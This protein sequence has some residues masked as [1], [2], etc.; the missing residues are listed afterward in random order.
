MDW[1]EKVGKG[2]A[3]GLAKGQAKGLAEV[4]A[5]ALFFSS[6]TGRRISLRNPPISRIPEALRLETLGCATCHREI[7]QDELT[8]TVDYI[9][10][11]S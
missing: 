11:T 6:S 3:K 8:A 5:L 1:S 10:V 7:F 9:M 4:S 2:L